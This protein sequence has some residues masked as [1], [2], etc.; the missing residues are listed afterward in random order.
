MADDTN[1][2]DLFPTEEEIL[3]TGEKLRIEL[4]Q[5]EHESDERDPLVPRLPYGNRTTIPY[6]GAILDIGVQPLKENLALIALS[7][8]AI[9]AVDHILIAAGYGLRVGGV[10]V[11]P[12]EPYRSE[13]LAQH[14]DKKG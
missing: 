1:L 8:L 11:F 5:E 10:L 4:L 2:V 9:P 14:D 3:K 6:R 12:P 7:A 13:W